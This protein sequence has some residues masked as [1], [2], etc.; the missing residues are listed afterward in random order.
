MSGFGQS[1]ARGRCSLLQF[2][3]TGFRLFL[4]GNVGVGVS[5]TGGHER[6][7]LAPEVYDHAP[8]SEIRDA[9][10]LVGKQLLPNVLP[11]GLPN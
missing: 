11:S 7:E 3:V 8:Q 1:L 10:G 5:G 2:R 6:V 9:L 4:D